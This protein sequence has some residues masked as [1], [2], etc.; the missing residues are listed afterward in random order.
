MGWSVRYKILLNPDMDPQIAPLLVPGY[1]NGTRNREFGFTYS[2]SYKIPL[3]K[4]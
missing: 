4:K 3:I 1:G 2:I